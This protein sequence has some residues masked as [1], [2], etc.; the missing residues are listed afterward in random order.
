MGLSW[1]INLSK[2]GGLTCVHRCVSTP[3]RPALSWQDL[4]ME[5]SGTGC[6]LGPCFVLDG[7]LLMTVSISLGH[8]G[9][10]KY[11]T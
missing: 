2:T 8:I 5:S 3:G 1:P 11:F 7:R 4:G 6:D 9:L 10:L